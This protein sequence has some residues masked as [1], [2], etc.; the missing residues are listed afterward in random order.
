MHQEPDSGGSH[1]GSKRRRRNNRAWIA[2]RHDPEEAASYN[3]NEAEDEEIDRQRE[4]IL[5][6]QYL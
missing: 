6:R 2:F 1:C 3:P 4:A 5:P